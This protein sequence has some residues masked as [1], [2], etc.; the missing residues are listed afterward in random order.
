MATLNCIQNPEWDTDYFEVIS[1]KDEYGKQ[2]F[3]I[4]RMTNNVGRAQNETGLRTQCFKAEID[5]YIENSKAN[6]RKVVI[7]DHTKR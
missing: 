5:W 7:I 3:D 1:L 6:G 4:S 2:S